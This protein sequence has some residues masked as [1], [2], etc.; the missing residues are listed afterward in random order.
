[1]SAADFDI[2]G[3]V[4][5]IT[6]AS[7]G[8]G[9]ILARGYGRAGC[10]VVIAARRTAA[11]EELASHI[12]AD[13][14]RVVVKTVDVRDPTHAATLVDAA[15]SELGRLDG[16]VL[17][18]GMATVAPAE[19]EPIEDFADVLGVNVTA[20]MR[21]ARAAA[22]AMIP[23]GGGWMITL[24]SIL[25]SR[26][27][28]GG[29]VAGYTASKGAVEQLTR[30]LARQWAPHGIRVNALSPGFFPT[31]MNAAMAASPE[32]RR[33]LLERIPLARTGEP[34]DLVGAAIFLASP[35][36]RYVTGHSLAVDGGM[37]AW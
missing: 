37:S 4:V 11:L 31:E 10:D 26:A 24:S 33:A 27:G 6:G 12:R 21:L 8:L 35:A 29:G 9:R 36:A 22:R 20:Q 3:Q 18:A 32:R 16:V 19:N 13:G 17:N 15:I 14:A 23:R 30:E 5:I 1:V 7:S 34:E 2:A 25:G 28:T